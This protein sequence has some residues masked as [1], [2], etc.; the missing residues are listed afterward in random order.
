V[1]KHCYIGLER[2]DAILKELEGLR[3]GMGLSADEEISSDEGA[4]PP[5]PDN[6][7]AA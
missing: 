3:L 1:T 7:N 5:Q 6:L 4:D 2:M